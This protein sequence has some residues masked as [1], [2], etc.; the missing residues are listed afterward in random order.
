[1]SYNQQTVWEQGGYSQVGSKPII[2]AE[3][4]CESGL[5]NMDL[6]DQTHQH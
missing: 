4:L 1:M 3:R 2:V 5:L 6:P